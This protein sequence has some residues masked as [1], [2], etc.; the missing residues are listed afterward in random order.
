[1]LL[2]SKI[3]GKPCEFVEKKFIKYGNIDINELKN[4][5]NKNLKNSIEFFMKHFNDKELT[6]VF[7]IFLENNNNFWKIEKA[8]ENLEMGYIRKTRFIAYG[9]EIPVG[10]YYAKRGAMRNIR[11]IMTGK[12]N[13]IGSE[14]I[15]ERLRE[16][17]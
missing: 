1:M 17:Y 12:L 11:T 3:T 7:K 13:N 6:Q 4:L 16:L 5:Y 10:Y 2:R 9:P 8:I 14:E 15:K